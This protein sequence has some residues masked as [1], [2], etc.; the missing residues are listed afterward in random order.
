VTHVEQAERDAH[1]RWRRGASGNPMGRPIGSK[2]QRRRLKAD[3]E[4]AAEWTDHDWRVFYQRTFQQT[5]GEQHEKHGAAW[6]ECMALWLLLNPPLQQTGLCSQC[7]RPLD[8]PMSSVSGAPIRIDGTWVHW[9][10]APW[11]CRA[12][13]ES[14]KNGLSRLGITGN[15]S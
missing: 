9:G 6:A 1:G 4:R 2:N 12:R 8:I 5:Q 7:N 14:A 15:A 11:F 10:C 13:W 3:P